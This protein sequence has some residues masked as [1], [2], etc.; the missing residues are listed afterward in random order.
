MRRGDVDDASPAVLAHRGQ[1][2]TRGVERR[3][4][5]D[6]ENQLPLLDRELLDRGDMLDPGVVDHDIEAAGGLEDAVDHVPDRLGLRHV[7]RRVID[8]DLEFRAEP[9]SGRRDLLRIAERA[10]DAQPDAARRSRYQRYFA[11]E[12]A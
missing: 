5:I 8:P 6:G 11:F 3:G 10:G 1:R 7:G 4:Q 2:A 9:R 12:H